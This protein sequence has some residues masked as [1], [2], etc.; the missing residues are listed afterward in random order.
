LFARGQTC[1]NVGALGCVSELGGE[2]KKVLL[3]GL[4]IYEDWPLLWDV[5]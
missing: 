3:K 4:T 2:S 1:R 5:C